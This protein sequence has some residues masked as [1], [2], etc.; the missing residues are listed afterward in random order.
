VN[1]NRGSVY[2]VFEYAEHDFHGIID[3]RIR[4]D[5][6]HIKCVMKQVLTGLEHLHRLGILHRD[7]KGGN[8]LLNKDGIVKL[9]DFGLARV[10]NPNLDISYTNRVVTLWYRAPELLLGLQKYN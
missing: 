9:A 10:F 3:S 7:I 5:I 1:K 2:L 6:H 4:F 8:I